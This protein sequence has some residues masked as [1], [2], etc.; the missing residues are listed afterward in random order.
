ML[1]I[2]EGGWFLGQESGDAGL[3]SY[4]MEGRGD[5]MCSCMRRSMEARLGC[6]V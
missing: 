6:L 4:R 2:V 1:V 5:V 3:G